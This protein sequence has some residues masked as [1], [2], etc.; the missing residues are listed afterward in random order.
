MELAN[1]CRC[2]ISYIQ[3]K[4]ET[5][6]PHHRVK[7]LT[8]GYTIPSVTSVWSKSMTSVCACWNKLFLLG[9]LSE[10]QHTLLQVAPSRK[11]D[12]VCRATVCLV[13]SF[14]L[15]ILRSPCL[16]IWGYC[17][18]F[19][20]EGRNAVPHFS[21]HQLASKTHDGC[22]VMLVLGKRRIEGHKM[23]KEWRTL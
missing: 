20:T 6:K 5:E 21:A 11:G 22:S 7:L 8:N 23:S 19:L 4:T 16:Q 3:I 17:V 9:G 12:A 13:C 14:L 2:C 15:C 1:P 10:P 18:R